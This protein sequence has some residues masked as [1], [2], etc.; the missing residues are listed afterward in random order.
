YKGMYTPDYVSD[1]SYFYEEN[2]DEYE[3]PVRSR[4]YD[5]YQKF[6]Y[7]GEELVR[8][9]G[10]FSYITSDSFRTIATKTASR[11]LL[12]RNRLEEIL[13]TNPDT[14]DAAVE[15]AIFTLRH[16][17]A[18]DRDYELLY[19]NGSDTPINTYQDLI[20]SQPQTRETVGANADIEEVETIH[21]IPSYRIPIHVY[22]QN[23]RKTFFEPNT[24]N[25]QVYDKF[26]RPVSDLF[27]KWGEELFD[28]DAQ[29]EN[30]DAIETEHI[31]ELEPGDTTILGLVTWGGEGLKTANNKEHIAN[32]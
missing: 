24:G 11:N 8:E 30:L 13:V 14:F 22:R 7:R 3:M 1:L 2:R 31:D 32:I 21:D 6:I 29:R 19:V 17:D 25:Q 26:V 15:A 10:I 16:Q 20:Q 12:Q 5:L 28:V 9:N 27:Q 18:R 23:I 4:M